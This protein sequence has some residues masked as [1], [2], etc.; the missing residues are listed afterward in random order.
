MYI[1]IQLR[2][3]TKAKDKTL[4]DQSRQVKQLNRQVLREQYLRKKEVRS[5]TDAAEDANSTTQMFNKQLQQNQQHINDL[6]DQI[7]KL[8][9]NN[10]KLTCQLNSERKKTK[11]VAVAE[12]QDEIRRMKQAKLDV[13]ASCCQWKE[14]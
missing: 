9:L 11:S 4:K 6:E 7:S 3:D 13:K 2:Q 12:H 14:K 10:E 5:A 8:K 1:T